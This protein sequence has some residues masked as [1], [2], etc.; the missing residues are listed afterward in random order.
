MKWL[1]KFMDHYDSD[2][3]CLENEILYHKAIRLHYTEPFRP[4]SR[5]RN[6]SEH[7]YYFDGSVGRSVEFFSMFTEVDGGVNLT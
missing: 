7:Y 1:E 4:T 6:E 3:N 2:R 5:V